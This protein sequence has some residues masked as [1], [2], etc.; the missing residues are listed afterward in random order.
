[1]GAGVARASV[2]GRE[3]ETGP[4]TGGATENESAAE[5]VIANESEF[6]IVRGKKRGADTGDRDK[7]F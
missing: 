6:E 5:N 7:C 2:T 1:M 3:S 4:G